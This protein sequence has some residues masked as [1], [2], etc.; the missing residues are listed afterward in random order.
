MTTH[1]PEAPLRVV[2]GGGLAPGSKS[3]PTTLGPIGPWA[4]SADA[5]TPVM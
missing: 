3:E 5:A 1:V 2:E 4:E